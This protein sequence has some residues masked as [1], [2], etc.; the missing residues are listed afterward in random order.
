MKLKNPEVRFEVTNHC[1]YDCVICPREEMT[2][3]KGI[4]DF[5]L[6]CRLVDEG[7]K[8]GLKYVTLT[9]FGEPFIDKRFFDRTRYAKQRGLTTY[10]DTNGSIVGEKHAQQLIETQFDSIRFS[11]FGGSRET[12]HKLMGFDGYDQVVENV[13]RLMRLKKEIGS[14]YPKVGIYYVHQPGNEHETQA[15]IERWKNAVDEL[16]V[17]KAHNWM[18]TYHLRQGQKRHKGCFRPESGPLQIRWNGDAVACC[19]DFNNQLVMGNVSDGKYDSLFEDPRAK[20][21]ILA[22]QEGDLSDYPLCANCD[23]L[24]ETPDALIFS[25]EDKNKIGVSGNTFEE[26]MTA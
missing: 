21:L 2:R 9:S 16:S 5:D 26:M 19:F 8:L 1:N 3:T 23:Q 15:F 10:V 4:M 6:Y 20:K 14:K 12:Y 24:F 7:I 11:I 13:E 22:H 17:W 25:T 18:N